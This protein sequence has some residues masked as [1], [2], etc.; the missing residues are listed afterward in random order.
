MQLLTSGKMLTRSD[1]D[2]LVEGFYRPFD[3]LRATKPIVII[4][5][6]HRFSRAQKA[7]KTITTELQPQM[8]IRFG[9]TFPEIIVGSGRNKVTVKDYNNLIYELNAC[10]AFNKNLIKGVAKEHFEPLSSKEEKVKIVSVIAKTSA[11]FQLRRQNKSPKTFT[12]E[13]GDSL[14]MID[15]VFE[16]IKITAIGKNFIE[17]SNGQKNTREKSLILIFIR[18]PIRNKW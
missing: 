1:Y 16:G 2:Y 18:L 11:N 13:A 9:A 4:D 5:E 6:A 7:Y 10:D 3:A 14:S 15:S 17:L 8:I 12:L